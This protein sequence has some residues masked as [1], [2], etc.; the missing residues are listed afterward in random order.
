[1]RAE[2]GK[3]AWEEHRVIVS[4]GREITREV[5]ALAE[6]NLAQENNSNKKTY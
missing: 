1:M 5:K 4:T 6:A 2:A 3:V